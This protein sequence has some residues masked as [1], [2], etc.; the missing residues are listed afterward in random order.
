MR[1]V[2][3]PFSTSSAMHSFPRLRRH[4]CTTSGFAR[5]LYRLQ[6]ESSPVLAPS[7]SLVLERFAFVFG[8]MIFRSSL[9]ASHCDLF[10]VRKSEPAVSLVESEDE[11]ASSR[12][13]PFNHRNCWLT[14]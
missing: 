9:D 4:V 6:S 10:V 13:P 5:C 7:P 2:R 14:D 3:I 8:D 11:T 1:E 12:T